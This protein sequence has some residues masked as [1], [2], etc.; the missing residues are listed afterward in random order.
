MAANPA[1]EAAGFISAPGQAGADR[2][3][4][5]APANHAKRLDCTVLILGDGY[6]PLA[7]ERAP[8]EIVKKAALHEGQIATQKEAVFRARVQKAG[9][10]SSQWS[11]TTAS[12]SV[13]LL[14]ARSAVRVQTSTISRRLAARFTLRAWWVTLAAVGTWSTRPAR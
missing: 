3:P 13:P 5:S 2:S 12:G 1:E 9:E 6:V 7:F 14:R 4:C 8:R 11:A 10:D